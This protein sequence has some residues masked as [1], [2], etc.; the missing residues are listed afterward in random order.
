[1]EI[2]LVFYVL[3]VTS[4]DK[5]VALANVITTIRIPRSERKEQFEG[6]DEIAI[7]EEFNNVIHS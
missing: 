6:E 7:E 5:I 3:S 4:R 2:L 1:M